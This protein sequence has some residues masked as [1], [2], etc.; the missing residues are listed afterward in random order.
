MSWE[1]YLADE[2]HQLRGE[3]DALVARHLALQRD[4]ADLRTE[5]TAL[6]EKAEATDAQLRHLYDWAN[7]LVIRVKV[8]P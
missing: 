8:T 6:R 2:H 1:G 7:S 4:H 5:F 3:H